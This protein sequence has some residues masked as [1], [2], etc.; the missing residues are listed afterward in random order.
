MTADPN[1][2]A[3]LYQILGLILLCNLIAGIMRVIRGPTPFDR[4]IAV[5]FFGTVGVAFLLL[6]EKSAQMPA[7]RDVALMLAILAPVATIAFVRA[8]EAAKRERP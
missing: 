1:A 5:Q 8:H 6:L 7:L 4:M 2:L 3:G